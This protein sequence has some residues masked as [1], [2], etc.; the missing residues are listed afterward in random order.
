MVTPIAKVW[1]YCRFGALATCPCVAAGC[2]GDL[3]FFHGRV[4]TG[5]V[6]ADAQQFTGFFVYFLLEFK[7]GGK[8]LHPG[9][10][11]VNIC[12]RPILYPKYLFAI[13]PYDHILPWVC[14]SLPSSEAC[15]SGGGD[16]GNDSVQV[17]AGFYH[18]QGSTEHGV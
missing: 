2:G 13:A 4:S 8:S 6:G 14:K 10:Y 7:V 15:R 17:L 1:G 12:N 9:Q 16:V 11:M 18:G 5:A 3:F